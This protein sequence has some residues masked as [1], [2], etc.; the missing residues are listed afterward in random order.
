[1]HKHM[2]NCLIVNRI[3]KLVDHLGEGGPQAEGEAGGDRLLVRG[4]G[5]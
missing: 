4:G 3:L 1:V 5:G 2:P